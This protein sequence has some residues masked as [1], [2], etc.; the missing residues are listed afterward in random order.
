MSPLLTVAD[1]A[2]ILTKS[3]KWVTAAARNGD[4]PSR[5]VGR[6]YRF[7]EADVAAYVEGAASVK[8]E[9]PARR[10]RRAA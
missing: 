9:A 2:A 7:T 4:L 6:T 8:T 10:R 3:P 1:V 5:K